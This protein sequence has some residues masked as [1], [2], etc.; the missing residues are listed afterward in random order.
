[1]AA[2]ALETPVH[3]PSAS[4][5]RAAPWLTSLLRLWSA[6]SG[7]WTTALISTV[8]I[9]PAR[10][11]DLGTSGERNEETIASRE[12]LRDYDNIKRYGAERVGDRDRHLYQPEG[13]RAGNFLFLPSIGTALVFNDN[14]LLTNQNRQ[15]DWR[16]E[17]TPG[18]R[19]VSQLPRHSFD[20]SLGGRIV[21]YNEHEE[22]N[23]ANAFVKAGAA[24]HFDHAHTLSM[25]VLSRLDH[26]DQLDPFSP[27]FS[28]YLVPFRENRASIGLTR[29]AG[30]LYGTISATFDSFDFD[31]ARTASGQ[32]IS[33][34]AADMR[35]ASVEL[36]TGYRFSPGYEAVVKVRGLRQLNQGDAVIDRDAYGWE[37]LAGLHGE[38]SPLLRWRL[39][40]GYGVRE[41]DQANLDAARSVL[42]EAEIQW[43]PTQSMTITA[44]ARRAITGGLDLDAAGLVETSLR[45]RVDYEIYHNV[46][47]KFGVEFSDHDYIGSARHDRV[48]AGRIGVDWYLS[49]NWLLN[50]SYEHYVRDSNIAEN[51]LTRNVVMIGA[52]LRF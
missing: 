33:Q 40:G 2:A 9:V 37:V 48:I 12:R 31:D 51:D 6:I 50:V 44:M 1:M 7:L 45:A 20:L 26:T 4:A 35:T 30:R 23:Q 41:Y 14:V 16:A 17:I 36:R 19:V 38:A 11:L 43:L 8:P 10:A 29:D 32:R 42:A 46:V 28:R 18:L 21:E 15:A 13:I 52:K 5:E 49:K 3:C 47:L 34:D 22:L 27:T 24:L 39:L 25:S